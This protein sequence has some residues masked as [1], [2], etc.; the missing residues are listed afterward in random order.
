VERRAIWNRTD[1]HNSIQQ[2]SERNQASSIS[3]NLRLSN[4]VE[5][6]ILLD[7]Y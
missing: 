3:I 6:R 7:G 4:D 2:C 1:N 5:E